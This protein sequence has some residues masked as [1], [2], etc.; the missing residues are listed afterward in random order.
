MV[1]MDPAAERVREI[2][3]DPR[4]FGKVDD[5]FARFPAGAPSLSECRR[6]EVV[7]DFRFGENISVVGDVR[8]ENDGEQIEVIP[9]G[10][11]LEGDA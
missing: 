7:G 6:F 9:D 11:R 2:E 3:L 4:F 5:F 1:A 8:L 10:T